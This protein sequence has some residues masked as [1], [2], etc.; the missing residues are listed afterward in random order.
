MAATEEQKAILS[1]LRLLLIKGEQWNRF[2]RPAGTNEAVEL[3]MGRFDAL[4]QDELERYLLY[5]SKGRFGD[6]QVIYVEPPPKDS[7]AVAA[8]WYH[9][10]F[11]LT[12]PK[13]GFYFGIWS[14]RSTLPPTVASERRKQTGFLGFR[15]ETPEEGDNHNYYHAQPC[16]SMADRRAPIAEA[17]AIPDRHPTF[18]LAANS[19]VEL[20]LCLVTSIYGMSGLNRLKSNISGDA[21]TRGK[22]TL[23]RSLDRISCLQRGAESSSRRSI[24]GQGRESRESRR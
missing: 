11:D 8:I 17:L 19:S 2:G 1:V 23:I 12:I 3:A 4:T 7:S 18:P 22:T 5:R 24:G 14:A 16:R 13:C 15:Y 6:A 10:D 9:W 20:L 21:T